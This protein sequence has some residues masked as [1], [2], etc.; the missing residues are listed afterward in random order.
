MLRGLYNWMMSMAGHKH[1]D[2][3]LGAVSFAESSF[4]PLPPDI[5]LAPMVIQRPDQVWRLATI[6]TLASVLGALLGYGIGYAMAPL[7]LKILQFFGYDKGLDAFQSMI[8][9]YGVYVILAKGL[10]P[11]PFKLVTIASGIGHMNLLAFVLSCAVTRGVRFFAVAYMC[12]KFGPEITKMMEK[13]LY[14]TSSIL[15][16]L[17]VLGFVLIKV[18]PHG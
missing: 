16:A 17:L 6:C 3:I 9:Q 1:A 10:T 12:H 15:L 5:M 14:L 13:R 18:L 8:D 2:K 7:G 4:F 11:I